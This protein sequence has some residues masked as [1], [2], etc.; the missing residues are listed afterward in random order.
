M[1][2]APPDHLTDQA[3]SHSSAGHSYQPLR[4]PLPTAAALTRNRRLPAGRARHGE[5]FHGPPRCL[6][7]GIVPDQCG[8]GRRDAGP[9]GVQ[10]AADG[11]PDGRG[12]C[13]GTA[14]AAAS[15][16]VATA[17]RR[18]GA[19]LCSPSASA[20]RRRNFSTSRS[21]RSRLSIS[22]RKLTV[23]PLDGLDQFPRRSGFRRMLDVALTCSA[24]PGHSPTL[25][26]YRASDRLPRRRTQP[27]E[28][29]FPGP[30]A[31]RNPGTVTNPSGQRSGAGESAC[32]PGSVLPLAQGR[33]SSIWDCRCRQP[34]AVY[35]RASGGPPSNARA[36][37]RGFP[38]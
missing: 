31:G 5:G 19:D 18:S 29:A 25:A 23:S 34:R 32:R 6:S 9:D 12:A 3:A 26:S 1:G 11:R 37:N 36:G 15:C 10:F 8:P 30:E 21:S 28:G 20:R 38:S 13:P 22:S 16:R 7:Y 2:C 4:Q 17:T 14:P 33:R 35:P 24:K 27:P